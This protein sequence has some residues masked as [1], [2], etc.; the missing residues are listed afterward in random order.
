MEQTTID[1]AVVQAFA[2]WPDKLPL[3]ELDEWVDQNP[4]RV[5]IR[6]TDTDAEFATPAR[7]TSGYKL[8]SICRPFR[9]APAG[10]RGYCMHIER[11]HPVPGPMFARSWRVFHRG[12][13][14]PAFR[15]ADGQ[16]RTG[17]VKAPPWS[18]R[19]PKGI[20][21]ARPPSRLRQDLC[22]AVLSDPRVDAKLC[23]K[24]SQEGKK[25]QPF[26]SAVLGKEMPQKEMARYRYLIDCHG[27]DALGW[28]MQTGPTIRVFNDKAG[29]FYWFDEFLRDREHY[30]AATIESVGCLIDWLEANEDEAL[31]VFEAG[32]KVAQEVLQGDHALRYAKALLTEYTRRMP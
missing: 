8:D 7:P 32:R 14:I 16:L 30:F 19:I 6:V 11:E 26:N 24:K 15:F 27:T 20:F 17:P 21:R 12:L 10:F 25:R 4:H 3:A 22:E 5:V 2:L 18:E 29:P 1:R 23:P 28:K 13:L 31:R 9:E